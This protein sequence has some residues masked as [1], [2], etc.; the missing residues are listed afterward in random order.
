MAKSH[1]NLYFLQCQADYFEMLD[2]L[3]EFKELAAEGKISQEEYEQM[4]HEIEL[5][6]SNYERLAYIM[7]LLNKPKDKKNIDADMNKSWYQALSGA[8]KE[9]IFDENRDVLADLKLCIQKAK[10]ESN[11]Q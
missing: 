3:K 10:G 8:S 4:L 9:V 6:K 2:N 11:E 5:V 7:M 1:V